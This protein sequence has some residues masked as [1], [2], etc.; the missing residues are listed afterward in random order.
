MQVKIPTRV[1]EIKNSEKLNTTSYS[2][3]SRF[4]V[5]TYYILNVYDRG[6]ANEY[7]KELT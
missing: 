1:E 7:F 4:P 5:L 2:D 6:N 3:Q